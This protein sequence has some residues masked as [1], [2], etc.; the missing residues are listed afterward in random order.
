MLSIDR[1][2]VGDNPLGDVVERHKRYGDLVEGLDIIVLCRRG[3]QRR[4]LSQKV[5][6]FP[7]NSLSRL[8]TVVDAYR[9]ACQLAREK[10]GRCT[11][12]LIVTQDPF[13]TG[14]AG[15][16]LK[17]KWR[18]WRIPL[19]VNLHGDY[20]QNPHFKREHWRNRLLLPLG[21]F[22]LQR[23]DA[24]RVMSVGQREKMEKR[25]PGKKI[26]VISTPVNVQQFIE[27]QPD[28]FEEEIIQRRKIGGK[29][30]ILMIGRKD[31]VKDFKTLFSAMERIIKYYPEAVLLLVGNYQDEELRS[32]LSGRL[33]HCVFGEGKVAHQRLPAYYHL[34][35]I[36][37]LSSVSESFGKVL[38][39]ANASG[40]PCVATQTTGAEE[41][42][43]SGKNGFLVPIGDSHLLAEKILFLLKNPQ[44]A[45]EMGREGRRRMTEKYLNNTQKVV[46]YWR[47]I[48]CQQ[49][50]PGS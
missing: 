5:R 8:S 14:I 40:K 13:A 31:P 28:S 47:S 26:A 46:D 30:V 36:V 10:G 43:E 42:I 2:L 29:K 34:A 19:L 39:E 25:F 24:L 38:V 49:E 12:D 16:L 3:F 11:Y 22:I 23:A 32:M 7:T 18:R 15:L 37:V 35:D 41:I 17:K 33:R 45:Q 50:I 1:G 6:T 44:I 27:Y 21:I 20:F 48:I 4:F 9:L